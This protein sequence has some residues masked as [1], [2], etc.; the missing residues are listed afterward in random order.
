M[1]KL[2]KGQK[3]IQQ[4]CHFMLCSFSDRLTRIFKS[5]SSTKY[6]FIKESD[7]V[8]CVLKRRPKGRA[9]ELSA[10]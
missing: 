3:Y 9:V 5:K 6:T 7:Q 8:S 1:K 4:I 10:F 2:N